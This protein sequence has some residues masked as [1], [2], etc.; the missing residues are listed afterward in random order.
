MPGDRPGHRMEH[1]EAKTAMN[2]EHVANRK[3]SDLTTRGKPETPA[4]KQFPPQYSKQVLLNIFIVYL[5]II[6]YIK[7]LLH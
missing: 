2:S 6:V 1:G 4:E 3:S 5:C 7:Q